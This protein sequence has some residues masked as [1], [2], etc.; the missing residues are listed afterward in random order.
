M[1]LSVRR[2]FQ[3]KTWSKRWCESNPSGKSISLEGKNKYKD[4]KAGTSFMF[5]EHK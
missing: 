3:A 2:D 4:P 5:E 1:V